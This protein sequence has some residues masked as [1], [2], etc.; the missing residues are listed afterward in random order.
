MD[1]PDISHLQN[2]AATFEEV[3]NFGKSSHPINFP[4]P[5]FSAVTRVNASVYNPAINE[6]AVVPNVFYEVRPDGMPP[7]RAYWIGRK[8]KRAIYGCVRSCTVLRVREGGWAGPDGNSLWEITNEMAAVKI[9]D[10]NLVEEM[11]GRHI[12]DPLKEV[13]AMQF[14]CRDDGSGGAS[15]VLD[16]ATNV[17]PCWDLF[18]DETYIYL[19][20]PFCSSGEL[21]GYVDRNGRFEEPV[22]KFWFRQLLNG[23]YHLQKKG[24]CH[25]DISLENVLVNEN[26][27]A[28][29]IDLGM[30][31]RI[32]YN[33]PKGCNTAYDASAQTLRKLMLPQGQCGK[34]N[35]ISP[36]ILQNTDPFDGFAIDI[37]AAG[38]VLFIM[39]VG[40]PPFEWASSDDPR[41]R[42]ICRGGLQQLVEQ[43]QRPISLHAIDLLQNMLREDPR[44]RLSLFQ[45]LNHPWV[46]ED[47]DV[48]HQPDQSVEDWRRSVQQQR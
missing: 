31:I 48:R 47:F 4:D 18:K 28:L 34:P 29:V 5:Q 16:G 24:I 10:L 30:C 43:W 20:M 26:T 44:D 27:K 19:V 23:L 14:F 11:R 2:A 40:L 22:A 36:E 45:I 17:M 41:F 46:T 3:L 37:W 7:P 21:F 38:I 39:L 6:V 9:I 15:D 25:R 1:S 8:L 13:A 33:S 35:Y 42:L 32:P 12:E